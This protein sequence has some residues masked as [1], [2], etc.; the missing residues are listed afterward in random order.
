M[1]DTDLYRSFYAT[2]NNGHIWG[3]SA[4]T[5]WDSYVKV[6][7]EVGEETPNF[8]EHSWEE[9][10]GYFWDNTSSFEEFVLVQRNPNSI[11]EF[12]EPID[13]DESVL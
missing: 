12:F 13:F 2:C 6:C 5:V 11:P 10:E 8:E 3:I 7:A 4:R 9:L 1:K